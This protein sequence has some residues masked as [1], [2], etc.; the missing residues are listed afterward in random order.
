MKY[1]RFSFLLLC[2]V[3]VFAEEPKAEPMQGL[4]PSPVPYPIKPDDG[5]RDSK[6]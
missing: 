3:L 4:P 5:E 2:A 6:I 1:L